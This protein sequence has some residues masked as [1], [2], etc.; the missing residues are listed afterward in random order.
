MNR[1]GPVV[2]PA[3]VVTGASSGIGEACA[4]HLEGLGFDVFAGVRKQA[5]ADA[6]RSRA[7]AH[8]TPIMIDVT[9]EGTIR[10]AAEEVRTAVGPR[11]LHGLVNNAGIG[12]AGPL[13]VLPVDELRR[14]FEVN[15]IGQVAVTQAFLSDI[16]KARGRIVFMGSVAGRFSA[17][18]L[19]PY[20][21]SKHAIEALTD[22]LRCEL[23]PWG[24]QVAVVEPGSI[25]TPIW[26][27]GQAEAD[28][29]IAQLG[30]GA[31]EL[32]GEAVE[33]VR[34]YARQRAVRGTPPD[35]V[36][37]AVA[38]F[39]TSRRPKTRYMV[40]LG[41]RLQTVLATVAPDRAVD[42]LVSRQLKLPKTPPAVRP[43]EPAR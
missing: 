19:G 43:K 16:R 25:A 4:L 31:E 27:K 28:R 38:H 21:A 13:E 24:I 12:V 36:A 11:G 9:D 2:R 33:R 37:E 3:V 8:L 30:A 22:A 7:S 17:P 32:Y 10:T 40:G 6:L 34:E 14:Q 26:D 20:S 23:R 1:N 35:R 41:A 18:F 29:L 39:L 5:D 15:V 42:A